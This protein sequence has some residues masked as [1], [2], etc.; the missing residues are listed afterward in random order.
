MLDPK[1]KLFAS[2]RIRNALGNDAS[3]YIGSGSLVKGELLTFRHG[4]GIIVGN[5]CY[6]GEGARLWSAVRIE[7]GDRTLISHNVNIFDNLT[8]SL[9]PQKRHAQFLA[10]SKGNFPKQDYLDE[11]SIIIG[12]DVLIGCQAIILKG[13]TIG[14]GSVIGAGAVVTNSVAANTIVGGNPA[15]VIRELTLEERGE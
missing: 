8:H 3:I 5:Y 9:N 15:R 1:A 6:I 4:G 13:V 2:A 10:I 12:E 11:Q 14:K 7:I